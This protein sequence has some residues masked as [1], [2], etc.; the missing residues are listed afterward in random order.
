[1]S[2]APALDKSISLVAAGAPGRGI[3]S[4]ARLEEHVH[5]TV[6]QLKKL[7]VGRGDFVASALPEGPDEAT[8][9]AAVTAAGAHYSPLDPQAS[10]AHYFSL[11]RLITP[12]LVL[13]HPATG[14]NGHPAR[15]AAGDLGIPVASVLR[16]FEAGIFTLETALNLPMQVAE[17]ATSLKWKVHVRGV[18]LVLIAPGQAYLRLANRLDAQN[19]VI[20]ITAPD[21]E[22][23]PGAHTIERVASECVRMLRRYRPFGPYA[24]AGWH[25]HGV[26]ALEMARLLEEEGDKVVFVAM[27]DAGELFSDP[28]GKVRR[29]V[30]AAT[31]LLRKKYT[32]TCEQLAEGLE[33]YRPRPWFGKILHLHSNRPVRD[34]WFE[35]PEIAPHGLASYE[36][37]ADM[38]A[39]PGVQIVAEILA[40]E[41]DQLRNEAAPRELKS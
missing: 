37:P 1:L 24:L 38:L 14:P 3:P 18:P 29:A 36:A 16:H 30:N 21:L 12:K 17:P 40:G 32:P 34:S 20:G 7:G 22:H 33:R 41:L 26:V 25:G 13:V 19:P 4:P 23:L 9:R 8:A 39:E 31:R 15:Q 28:A 6:K 27:L 35:W 2:P 11:L 5:A 10:R